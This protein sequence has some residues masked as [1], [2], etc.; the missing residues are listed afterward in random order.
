M[1]I[2]FSVFFL[3]CVLSNPNCLTLYLDFDGDDMLGEADLRQVVERLTGS[4]RLNESDMKHL[5]QNILDEA[6]LDED[7]A[8]SFAEFEHIIDKSSDFCRLIY[9]FSVRLSHAISI[10][11][12]EGKRF[13]SALFQHIPYSSMKLMSE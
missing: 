10:I 6:D 7:G 13:L 2:S 9:S 1:C 8:L 12:F 5:I 4:Q 3:L 11:V